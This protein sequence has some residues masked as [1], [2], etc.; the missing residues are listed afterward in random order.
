ML[1]ALGLPFCLQKACSRGKDL[2]KFLKP[3]SVNLCSC[4]YCL[5]N[6]GS[7]EK[8]S[9]ELGNR[10]LLLEPLDVNGY[11][12]YKYS[13]YPFLLFVYLT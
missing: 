1:H 8:V 10:E 7:H 6:H 2:I 9:L 3:G 4:I 12:M 11:L 13:V 5:E